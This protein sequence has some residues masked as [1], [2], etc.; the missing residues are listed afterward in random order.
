[1]AEESFVDLGFARVDTGRSRRCGF[2]EVIYG[3][4][5]TPADVMAIARTVLSRDSVLLVTRAG[6]RHFDAVAAEFPVA[7]W[8]DRARCITI[9]IEPL[10]RNGGTVGGICAGTSDLRVAEEAAVTL[11]VFGNNV[12][13]ITDVGVAGIHRLIAVRDRMEACAVLIVV[14]GMEGALPSAVAG[15]VSRP[16]IAVPTSVGY[17]ASFGGLAALLGMLN[18]CGSGVTVVNIDNGFGAGY[19]AAQINRGFQR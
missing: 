12:D 3:G 1:M 6:R 15:L 18:S 2:P 16:V 11:E 9:E 17:G 8:H 14:A 4:G 10:P 13:R 7:V 5:K 19:A